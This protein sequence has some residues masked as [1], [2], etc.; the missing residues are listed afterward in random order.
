LTQCEWQLTNLLFILFHVLSDF[1]LMIR[2]TIPPLHKAASSQTSHCHLDFLT[3]LE[4]EHRFRLARVSEPFFSFPGICSSSPCFAI[5]LVLAFNSAPAPAAPVE[6]V[7]I[8]CKS[9][10]SAAASDRGDPPKD[11]D[12]VVAVVAL[13]P[14]S[15]HREVKHHA[16]ILRLPKTEDLSSSGSTCGSTNSHSGG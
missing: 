12:I 2:S 4:I 7:G 3:Q 8:G 9:I 16:W 10:V 11:N 15:N 13:G 6:A 1:A 5:S 14:R